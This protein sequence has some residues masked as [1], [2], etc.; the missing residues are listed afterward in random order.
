MVAALSLFAARGAFAQPADDFS[1]RLTADPRNPP[2]FQRQIRAPAGEATRFRLAQSD[3]DAGPPS[4]RQ[5]K[6]P[7]SGAAVSGFD[8]TNAR[9]KRSRRTAVNRSAQLSAAQIATA[10]A[11]AREAQQLYRREAVPQQ[12]GVVPPAPLAVPIHRRPRSDDDPFAP[13]GVRAGSFTLN[14]AVE[15]LGGY[16]TNPLRRSSPRPSASSLIVSPELLVR[17]DWKRHALNAEIRGSMIWYNRDFDALSSGPTG[18]A[19]SGIPRS[20]DR[21]SLDAKTN[22]RFDTHAGS[23]ADVEGRFTLGTDNPGSP[24]ISAGLARLPIYTRAGVTLGY[25]QNFNRLDVTLKGGF[26]RISYQSS[27]LTDGTR[28]SNA[29]RDYDQFSG[30]LRTSYE[31]HPGVKPFAEVAV[32]RREHYLVFDRSGIRRD[33]TGV[34]GRVGTTFELSR[35]LTGEISGGYLN[36]GY[37]DPTLPDI[38]G[39]IA[40]ASLIWTATALT[41]VTLAAKST[42]DESIV[43]D[44]SG[45]L[46][47]DFSLQVDHVFRRWLVGTFRTGMGID[48]YQASVASREDQRFFV[49]AA[50]VYKLSREFQLKGE[51]RQDWL[52]S[53]QSGV[54]YSATSFLAGVRWQH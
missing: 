34:S 10:R 53:N 44:V 37:R 21:P 41:T 49:A 51:V 43:A 2:R 28:S 27:E 4:A 32:D 24:N 17:S 6:P 22:G 38:N 48:T 52:T 35:K 40:D 1:P 12:P 33:S 14:P 7:V 39:L 26:D 31:F 15:L 13:V 54:D 19:D 25:T 20:L 11:I 29:D 18:L 36:R 23:H 46:R 47:R 5:E 16:D 45:L 30:A 50:L 3:R 8:S 42:S 9:R